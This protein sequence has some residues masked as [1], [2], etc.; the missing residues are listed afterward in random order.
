MDFTIS[1]TLASLSFCLLVNRS[2]G[3]I[4]KIHT[5]WFYLLDMSEMIQGTLDIL[6]ASF[7]STSG[8]SCLLYWEFLTS[9][10]IDTLMRNILSCGIVWASNYINLMLLVIWLFVCHTCFHEAWTAGTDFRH[11]INYSGGIMG[12]MAYQI[13]CVS[14]VYPTVCSRADQGKHQSPRHW[15]LWGEFTGDRW[16]P[17]TKGQ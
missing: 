16:I 6:W 14:S 15:P 12:A 13:I 17:H 5:F 7:A 10:F 4:T 11:L 8:Y 1:Q 2:F 3:K 9:L